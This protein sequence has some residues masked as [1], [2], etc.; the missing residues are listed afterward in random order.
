MELNHTIEF[1]RKTRQA[2]WLTYKKDS[3]LLQ[4]LLFNSSN[5]WLKFT[6]LLPAVNSVTEHTMRLRVI[7]SKKVREVVNYQI[8][9]SL[10]KLDSILMPPNCLTLKTKWVPRQTNL[11]RSISGMLPNLVRIVRKKNLNSWLAINTKVFSLWH[12]QT[13]T[14]SHQIR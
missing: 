4:M 11:E 1:T 5:W 14:K 8:V 13:L 12:N 6:S 9:E 7:W 2:W 10:F 3:I